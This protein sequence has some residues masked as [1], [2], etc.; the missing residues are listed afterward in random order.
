[1]RYAEPTDTFDTVVVGKKLHL[2]A[3]ADYVKE[4]SKSGRI[5]T[6]YVEDKLGNTARI[7][8]VCSKDGHVVGQISHPERIG[9]GLTS[10]GHKTFPFISSAVGYFAK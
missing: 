1:M 7:D 3:D 10:R 6:Q 9:D 5:L 2:T 4:L 8:A